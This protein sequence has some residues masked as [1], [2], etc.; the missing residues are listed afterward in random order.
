MSAYLKLKSKDVIAVLDGDNLI[1][2]KTIDGQEVDIRMP[3]LSGPD[4]CSIAT[5]FGYTNICYGKQVSRWQYFSLLLESCDADNRVQELLNYL[6][7]LSRFKDSLRSYCFE[8]LEKNHNEIVLSI[9]SGINSLLRFSKSELVLM[10]GTINI[11]DI[12]RVVK[13]E[14]PEISKLDRSYVKS[15]SDRSY[16]DIETGDFDSA[17]TKCRTL[18]EEVLINMIESINIAVPET[19]KIKDLYK[20]VKTNYKLHQ[21]SQM[22]NR[23]NGLLSGLEKIIDSIAEMRNNASDSHGIGQKRIQI[24]SHHARLFVNTS[25]SL[26]DFLISVK[27]KANDR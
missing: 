17:I 11:K 13:I 24:E 2:T 7:D 6:F 20:I 14:A 8:N 27:N 15:I 3:Y 22:D 25:T 21:D 12:D 4:I 9:I 26:A 10:N 19:G 18:I 16:R 5:K 23:I 1:E